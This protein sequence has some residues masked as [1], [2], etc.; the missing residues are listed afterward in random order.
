MPFFLSLTRMPVRINLAGTKQPVK[1]VLPEKDTAVCVLLDLKGS[2]A[3][4]V[5]NKAKRYFH[6][7]IRHVFLLE[8]ASA[9]N[10]LLP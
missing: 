8:F 7:K 1:L 9:P 5:I 3:R 6:K 2:I 10:D 4:T